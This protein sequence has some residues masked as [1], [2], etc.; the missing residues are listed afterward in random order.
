MECKDVE[1]RAG[2]GRASAGPITTEPEEGQKHVNE[3]V[4]LLLAGSKHLR[5][6]ETV[7]R[8]VSSLNPTVSKSLLL[9]RVL[10]AQ[11]LSSHPL[12]IHTF[13]QPGPS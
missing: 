9:T 5:T 12:T 1:G 2:Q 3:E 4:R 8:T 10:H 13:Q 7:T 6:R 11:S